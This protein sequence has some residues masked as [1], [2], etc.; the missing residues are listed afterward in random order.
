MKKSG[1]ASEIK[2]GK[3]KVG[4]G[5]P[6]YII[7]EIGSNFDGDLKRAKHLAKRAKEAGADA[8]KI[9]LFS[10]P[11]IASQVG[12]ESLPEFE[13]KWGQPV[14][15]IYKAAEFPREWVK[16]IMDYCK[17][18][19]IDFISSTFD[20]D[21]VDLLE[22]YKVSVHKIAAPEISHLEFV[23]YIARTGKPTIMSIGA[24]TLEEAEMAVKIFRKAKNDRLMLLQCVTGYPSPLEDSNL[25]AMQQL[26]DKFGTIVGFSDHTIGVEGGADDP[27]GGLTVPLGSVALGGKIIEKHVTDDRSRKEGTDHS[28]ALTFEEFALMVKG[29][30]GME[31]ALGDGKKRIMPSEKKWRV[32]QRR[33]MYA[34][35]AI[36]KGQKITRD[37]LI[38]LRPAVGLPPPMLPKVLGK[39]AKRAIAA[40]HPIKPH[41]IGR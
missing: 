16:E 7:A 25:L 5:H 1:F 34:V 13:A 31:A 10:T 26:K 38:M 29:V 39:K 3:R 30:R 19:G 20:V 24:A 14:I 32:T 41:D 40:G 33:G 28:F 23:E 12:F 36:A 27:L 11:Q 37:M 2:I 17:Q 4:A 8:F 6:T 22:K 35:R 21:G 9:Q 18:I 15:D